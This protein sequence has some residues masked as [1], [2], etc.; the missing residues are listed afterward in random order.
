MA[1]AEA[2]VRPPRSRPGV[3]IRL[4]ALALLAGAVSAQ[5][6]PEGVLFDDFTYDSAEWVPTLLADREA[7]AVPGSLFGLNEW[8][9]SPFGRTETRRL[10]YRY[11]WQES[12][13]V[14]P[15][16]QL[17]V[18]TTGLR[19]TAGPGAHLADGCP[20]GEHTISPQQVTT[21]FTARRGTWAARVRLGALPNPDHAS[22]I[23]AF[24]LMGPSAGL[25]HTS[26]ED[27]RV[28][29]E[30]DHEWNNR[31]FGA[32]Q[33]H[34]YISTGAARGT[35][36]GHRKAPMASPDALAPIGIGYDV[37]TDAAWTCS[38]SRHG[39]QQT[40]QASACA[41]LLRGDA[42]PSLEITAD[43]VWSTL[44]FEVTDH[45]IRFEL[46][47]EVGGGILEMRSQSLTPPT[48]LPLFAL[49]S[50]HLYPSPNPASCEDRA[51]IRQPVTFDVD[52]FFYTEDPAFERDT[53]FRT[54]AEIQEAGVPRLVTIPGAR[55]ER[56]DRPVVGWADR[57]GFGS[58][59]T[60]IEVTLE[61][62]REMAPGD[63][64]TVLALPPER[65]GTFRYTW[66]VT[67]YHASGRTSARTMYGSFALPLVFPRS[68]DRLTVRVLIEEVD[69][70]GDVVRTEV[71]RP[72]EREV[73]I[74]RR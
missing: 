15:E 65:H 51:D 66:T 23:H 7:G 13:S 45:G 12:S 43:S 25:V 41:S 44:F 60:P 49:L 24:W 61:A 55:L 4:L 68:A 17:E 74:Y 53:V 52:W 48:Q 16:R 20:D 56:P 22:M 50:Q 27:I 29:N 62:P 73:T 47:A 14:P 3:T 19:F 38:L 70:E 28:T 11:Q 40:L 30:I 39:R 35:P 69:D 64:T 34:D 6:L 63:T 33:A 26:S 58:R 37:V 18:T 5:P 71:I 72:F 67:T 57:W 10:W 32:P 9:V 54:V 8:V 46:L 36:E 42:V 2:P 31:F 21:G 59:T 1:V